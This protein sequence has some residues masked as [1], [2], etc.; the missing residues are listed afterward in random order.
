VLK[1]HGEL[2]VII[3]NH[4]KEAIDA[5]AQSQFDLVLM[6]M[7]MPVM[8]GLDATAELR[9]KG[10]TAPIVIVTGNIDPS[11]VRQCLD[12]GADGHLAKPIDA[13]ALQTLLDR[14]FKPH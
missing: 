11:H 8:N 9:K 7:E 2:D 14:Y 10:F 3:A 5:V 13:H 6:D 4:G 12:A 1:A